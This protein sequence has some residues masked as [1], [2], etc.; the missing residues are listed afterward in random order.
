M[1]NEEAIT[2]T[3][4]VEKEVTVCVHCGCTD[5]DPH[6]NWQMT[7][8]GP[9]CPECREAY[10]A[11]CAECGDIV[12]KTDLTIVNTGA[13]VC[14]HC[15]DHK[16]TRCARCEAYERDE[17]TCTVFTRFNGAQVICDDC[18]YEHT[19]ICAECGERHETEAMYE[20]GYHTGAYV[21]RNC[22]GDCYATCND[23]GEVHHLDHMVYSDRDDCSYCESCY[24]EHDADSIIQGYHSGHNNGLHFFGEG[25]RYYGIELEVE[26]TKPGYSAEDAAR[27]F[28]DTVDADYWH[29]ESD[30]SL[31]D[32]CEFISQPMTLDYIMQEHKE[33][34]SD[35]LHALALNG[36]RSHNT[37]HCGLHFHVSREALSGQDILNVV[38]LCN[39][40]KD[41]IFELSRRTEDNFLHWSKAYDNSTLSSERGKSLIKNNG[42]PSDR[43]MMVNLTNPHTIEFRFFRGTLKENSFFAALHFID[44][45]INTAQKF[46]DETGIYK[47]WDSD[48]IADAKA[49]STELATY[50]TERGL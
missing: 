32:G 41:I 7:A 20:I 43:Y 21:C 37:S 25:P 5:H 28:I 27:T 15:L 8:D 10:Y 13:L 38:V 45:I 19:S 42:S 22:Y 4:T 39:Q 31:D 47:I 46:T 44:Y 26:A 40:F 35:A 24:E 3:T 9:V 14:D 29:V 17:R 18:A 2:G 23:C 16:Y 11:V 1:L 34:L 49:Y 33:V 48:F 36:I 6:I 12:E 50:I 30:G